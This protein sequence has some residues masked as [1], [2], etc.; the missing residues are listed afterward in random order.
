MR[1][2]SN[3]EKIGI[4]WDYSNGTAHSNDYESNTNNP[5]FPVECEI[6]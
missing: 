6:D 3:S 1:L 2:L 5:Y 4:D